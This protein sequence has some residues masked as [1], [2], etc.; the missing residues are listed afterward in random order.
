MTKAERASFGVWF[1]RDNHPWWQSTG[2]VAGV[3]SCELMFSKHMW[4][5]ESKLKVEEDF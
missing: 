1:L 2:I 3:R 5:A 4:E